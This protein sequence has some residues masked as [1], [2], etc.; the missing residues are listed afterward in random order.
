[1]LGVETEVEI[2]MLETRLKQHSHL[3]SHQNISAKTQSHSE[4]ISDHGQIAEITKQF[5]D[6]PSS[7]VH[8]HMLCM[9]RKCTDYFNPYYT[10]AKYNV[11]I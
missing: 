3:L 6:V 8:H 11:Y 2:T 1:M 7:K 4:R 9:Q 10:C 5:P